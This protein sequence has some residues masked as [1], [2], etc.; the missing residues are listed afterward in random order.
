M[1]VFDATNLNG[2]NG[3]E[4]PAAPAGGS[5]V[6]RICSL[7][8]ETD[9]VS[10][11]Q[12][13]LI[14]ILLPD[15]DAAAARCVYERLTQQL[16]KIRHEYSHEEEFDLDKIAMDI[17][18]YPEK[19]IRERLPRNTAVEPATI[20]RRNAWQDS[21]AW[22]ASRVN[23]FD[24]SRL[25]GLQLGIGTSSGASIALPIVDAFLWGPPF[26]SDF[27]PS[28]E[29]TLKRALDLVGAIAGLLLLSPLLFLT[30]LLIKATSRGPIL[31]KQKRLGYQGEYFT[32]LKFRTMYNHCE[33]RIHQEYVKRLIHGKNGDINNGSQDQPFYKIKN[34]PR[35]TPVGRV[36]RKT[37][38]DELPQLWN[39]LAGEMSL[40]GPRPPLPYEVEEYQ[41]WHYRRIMEAKPGITGL[42]QVSGRNRTTFDEMVRL[43]LFYARNWSLAL[44]IKILLK[45]V[46]VMLTPNGV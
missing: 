16:G 17:L 1:I 12:K 21:F 34:D 19:P 22:R 15:T 26:V 20:G 44:D 28:V 41:K 32:F 2:G 46:K 8:R 42:W 18:S 6:K 27:V 31:F 3:H 5:L 33:N 24:S 23:D 35:I 29:K 40:V 39:V 9:V 10:L 36:L 30:A 45:T 43:D 4:V 25:K 38:I 37:S 14:L 13:N 7:I 11:Y